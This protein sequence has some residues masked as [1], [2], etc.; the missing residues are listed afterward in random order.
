MYTNRFQHVSHN[1][2]YLLLGPQL[3][4]HLLDLQLPVIL[5]GV[6]GLHWHL[7]EARL[8][9]GRQ[10]VQNSCELWSGVRVRAPAFCG[11]KMRNTLKKQ[12]Q[13]RLSKNDSWPRN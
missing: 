10:L 3:I 8:F 2:L 12:R 11:K 5:Q 9:D 4:K 13:V 7:K 1:H 6:E